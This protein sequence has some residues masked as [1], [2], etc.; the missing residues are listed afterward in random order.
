MKHYFYFL[1]AA[2][3]FLQHASAQNCTTPVSNS[4]FQQKYNLIQGMSNATSRFNQAKQFAQANCM[5][6]WQVKQLT[7]LLAS[8]YDKLEFCKTAF[9]NTTD[10]DNYYDVYDAF[11]YFSNVFRLH[12]YVTLQKQTSNTPPPT[13][14]TPSNCVTIQQNML[15]YPPLPYPDINGYLGITQCNIP[16]SDAVLNGHVQYLLQ[17]NMTQQARIDYARSLLL[18]NCFSTAQIMKLS[19]VFEM[20]TLRHDLIKKGIPRVFDRNNYEY[21]RY[22]LTNQSLIQD[23]INALSGQVQTPVVIPQTTCTVSSTDF[24]QIISS[25]KK[26]SFASTK[27]SVAKQAL[28]AKKCFTVA[29]IKEILRQFSF[30]DNRLDLAKF[31]WDYCTDRDNYFQI[32]DVF[33][34]SSSTE[35]LNR[36]LQ[37]K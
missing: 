5:S 22:V 35:E 1:A 10:K 18:S 4:F 11:A 28:Q 30:E 9:A 26:E 27:M 13:V 21:A 24:N 2:L 36:F 23:F 17:S 14:Y 29:Q 6:T 8:D 32:N 15:V 33:S 3:L 31:A 12:D 20:E 25:I 19:T 37:S 7:L 34:F 16:V